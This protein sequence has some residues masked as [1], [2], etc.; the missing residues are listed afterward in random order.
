MNENSINK[1]IIFTGALTSTSF[2][3]TLTTANNVLGVV[4]LYPT[5]YYILLLVG[6]SKQLKFTTLA[7]NF[8][9]ELLRLVERCTIP[10]ML[11]S[12]MG[13]TVYLIIKLPIY[14]KSYT[15]VP[16][17]IYTLLL[18]GSLITFTKAGLP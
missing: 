2:L 16:V 8:T 11:L 1:F 17:I 5:A 10:L 14:D 13:G 6:G 9:K 3:Y 7:P 4:I 18:A 15:V 12:S